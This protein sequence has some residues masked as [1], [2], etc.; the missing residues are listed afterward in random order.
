MREEVVRVEL[1]ALL[2]SRRASSGGLTKH[3]YDAE[4]RQ[5]NREYFDNYRRE[6]REELYRKQNEKFECECGGRH[7]RSTK[8]RHLKSK[9][10][11][12]YL[13]TKIE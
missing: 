3:E 9:K 4:Y 11:L 13:E 2:N 1:N 10:H 12:Q 8:N 7:T 5:E 6:H